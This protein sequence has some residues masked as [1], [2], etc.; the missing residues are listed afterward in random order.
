MQNRIKGVIKMASIK[1]SSIAVIQACNLAIM[2][3]EAKV[4]EIEDS[5]RGK[6][7]SVFYTAYLSN[8]A[9]HHN[10]IS[11]INKIKSLAEYRPGEI[12]IDQHD[13]ELI[14]LDLAFGRQAKIFSE[15]FESTYLFVKQLKEKLPEGVS[16]HISYNGKLMGIDLD[17]NGF[18]VT[19]GIS[20]SIFSDPKKV[21]D[22]I[23]NLI[24]NAK[25]RWSFQDSKEN[26]SGKM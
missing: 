26:D 22:V 19:C 8:T 9:W 10:Q 2:D 3:L 16:I 6:R 1:L 23:E 12:Q 7:D 11:K 17:K 21:K 15:Y 5:N 24:I 18:V 14:G 25:E 20:G 13:Y 4:E